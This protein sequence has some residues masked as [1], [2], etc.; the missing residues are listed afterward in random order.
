MQRSKAFIVSALLASVLAGGLGGYLLRPEPSPSRGL[1]LE[2][3]HQISDSQLVPVLQFRLD[4]VLASKR[5][6]EWSENPLVRS[7]GLATRRDSKAATWLLQ[8]VFDDDVPDELRL[9]LLGEMSSG[10]AGRQR[11]EREFIRRITAPAL[12]L[13]PAPELA[14]ILDMTDLGRQVTDSSCGCRVALLLPPS[15]SSDSALLVA[16][17]RDG[18]SGLTWSPQSDDAG[19]WSLQLR[20]SDAPGAPPVL[21][22]R[23]PIKDSPGTVYVGDGAGARMLLGNSD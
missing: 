20:R 17:S 15:D 14:R 12:T 11:L 10:P 2:V 23:L 19:D 16:W 3:V 4:E 21:I 1:Q 13:V 9:E 18:T 22:D 7:I 8:R 6:M 5:D